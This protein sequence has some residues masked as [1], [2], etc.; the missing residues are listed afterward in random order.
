MSDGIAEEIVPKGVQWLRGRHRIALQCW[1]VALSV[2]M[3]IKKKT[4]QSRT[5]L[6]E[7]DAVVK[8]DMI[9]YSAF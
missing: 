3:I 6:N 8:Y 2:L 1:N 7:P 5:R 4:G 9:L